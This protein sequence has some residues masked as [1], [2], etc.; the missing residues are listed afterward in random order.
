MES[1][2]QFLEASR[3]PNTMRGLASCEAT[4][5]RFEDLKS[6]S[7]ELVQNILA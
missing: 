5:A 7:Y 2:L 6:Q 3:A 1:P 4:I